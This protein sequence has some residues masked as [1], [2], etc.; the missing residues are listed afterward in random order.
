M[1]ALRLEATIEKEGELHLTN[2]PLHPSQHVEIIVLIGDEPHQASG[3]SL[4]SVTEEEW[5]QL[6]DTI[7]GSEPRFATLD[8]AMRASRGRP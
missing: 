2:L 4:P 3:A 1:Q 8:E 6:L 5:R 7:R